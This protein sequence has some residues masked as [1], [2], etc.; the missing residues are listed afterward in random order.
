MTARPSTDGTGGPMTPMPRR[1]AAPDSQGCTREGPLNWAECALN[2]S[3]AR[4]GLLHHARD[5]ASHMIGGWVC[6]ARNVR[7]AA[8]AVAPGDGQKASPDSAAPSLPVMASFLRAGPRDS[9]VRRHSAVGDVL[10]HDHRV[11]L[12]VPVQ[13]DIDRRGVRGQVREPAQPYPDE[14]GASLLI[15]RR[16]RGPAASRRRARSQRTPNHSHSQDESSSV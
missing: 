12:A 1:D 2:S 7:A 14:A 10:E 3:R 9:P 5:Q 15:R 6:W 8:G 11:G 13:V 16:S 4:R